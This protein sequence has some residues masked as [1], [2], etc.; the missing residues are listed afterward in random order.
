M[1]ACERDAL[2]TLTLVSG[3]GPTL[4]S[5]AIQALGSAQ[6]VLDAGI[7]RLRTIKGIGPQRA[8][9]LRQAMDQ[10]ADGRALAT[11]KQLIQQ[12]HVTLLTLDDAGYPPLLRLIHDPP[13]LLYVRGTLLDSD[14]LALGVVGTRR[15]SAYGRDQADR[16]AGLC[17]QA[18]L[19]IISGGALGIDTAAHRA[20]VRMRGRTI[21]VL[22]SGLANPYPPQN[23]R[24]FDTIAGDSDTLTANKP[25]DH[26]AVI[27]ELPM[28]TAPQRENF[29]SRN[30]IISGLSLG[31]LVVEA[32]Q[33]SG[34]LITA[35]IAAEDHNRE[36]MAL[37]GRVD[38]P[39]SAGCHQI[40]RQGWGAL[41]TNTA[42][43]LDALGDSGQLLKAGL[44]QQPPHTDHLTTTPPG[45]VRTV[46]LTDGQQR[47]IDALDQPR[48]LD[49]IIGHTGLTAS[50]L[51]ADLTLLEIRGLV[52]RQEGCYY[53]PPRSSHAG[54]AAANQT[55]YDEPID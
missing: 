18:G 45:P 42:D 44:R 27:S 37:P 9:Q 52:R 12:Y 5:R 21:A 10:L 38:S 11:E 32:P 43:I 35:R 16:L 36:V 19:C 15:C 48:A 46:N 26:G 22:G 41:V 29:P 17:A 33:R 50:T 53:L 4:T 28:A 14:R 23:T 55:L 49:Q 51:R 6:A 54:H 40:L 25:H 39:L 30:R 1:D 24:L 34:A 31:V 20:A 2:L 3:M 8:E 13:P 7:H 47:I